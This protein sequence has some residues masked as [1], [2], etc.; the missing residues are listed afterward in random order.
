M[1][2]RINRREMISESSLTLTWR[3]GLAQSFDLKRAEQA[4]LEE[5]AETG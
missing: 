5:W 4:E 2:L 1:P 3:H